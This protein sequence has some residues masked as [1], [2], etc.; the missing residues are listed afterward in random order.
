M[1]IHDLK[2]EPKPFWAVGVEIKTAE[3]RRDD[4]GF[5]VGD[6]IVLQEFESGEYTGQE[7]MLEITHIQTGFGI[8]DGYVM[9]SIKVKW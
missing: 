1:K 7:L 2:C 8:P 6:H 4:R 9:L 5:K 3:F